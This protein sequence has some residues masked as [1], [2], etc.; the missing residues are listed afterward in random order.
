M[1]IIATTAGGANLQ[2]MYTSQ[3]LASTI[4]H[5]VLAQTATSKEI[6]KGVK[7]SLEKK[8]R[9]FVVDPYFASYVKNRFLGSNILTASVLDF[10][11]GRGTTE[12]RTSSVKE[13]LEIGVDEID[14]VSKYHL[15]LE[16]DGKGFKED[17]R[18]IIKSMNGKNLKIILETDYLNL[19]QIRQAVQVICDLTKEENAKN[20]IVKTNTGFAKEIK[21]EN[22]TAVKIIKETLGK[23][24]L[25]AN[26]IEE[27]STGKIGI[28]ASRG[29]KTKDQSI[30]F[31]E[32]GA[33]IIGTSSGEK[34]IEN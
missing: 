10:P 27:I 20:L 23:N 16:G 8:F 7:V 12:S 21:T 19:D 25:Y 18:E 31:I 24:N 33:H 1:N 3:F 26:K 32:A 29:I 13:L 4:D 17:L 11:H 5:T 15:L 30:S 28:K 34:I 2:K 6:E 22:L 9:A 14:I